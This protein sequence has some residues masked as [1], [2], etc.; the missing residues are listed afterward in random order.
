MLLKRSSVKSH[1]ARPKLEQEVFL[2]LQKSADVLMAELSELL[3]PHGVSTTQYN[4]LRIL[5]GAGAVR[6]AGEK[7]GVPA[8]GLACGEIA[9]RMLTRDPDMTRLLDRLEQRKLVERQ[10]DA[11]DRRM[12]TARISPAGLHLLDA[13]DDPVLELHRRQLAHLGRRRLGELLELLAT[14]RDRSA[15]SESTS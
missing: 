14:V 1:Q 6:A 12:V 9:S 2:A 11:A 7:P 5:R 4:V 10:R 13:L 8:P 3:K 15:A